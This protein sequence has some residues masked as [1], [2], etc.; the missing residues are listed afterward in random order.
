MIGAAAFLRERMEWEESVVLVAEHAGDGAVG[1]VQLYPG[2]DSLSLAVSW[3][4]NDLYVLSSARGQ[5]VA[6]E[7]PTAIAAEASTRRTFQSMPGAMSRA[8]IPV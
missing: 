2:F 7:A 5:G 3:L 1:F 4:L 6:A 8:A